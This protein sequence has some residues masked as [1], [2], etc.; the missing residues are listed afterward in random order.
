MTSIIFAI[1]NPSLIQR[2]DP[3]TA[4]TIRQQTVDAGRVSMSEVLPVRYL[5]IPPTATHSSYMGVPAIWILR[6]PFDPP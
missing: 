1:P 5:S 6:E 4:W 2:F 3:S